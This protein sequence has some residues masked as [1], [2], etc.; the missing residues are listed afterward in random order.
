MSRRSSVSMST[1]NG[2]GVTSNRR[3]T[4]R[5]RQRRRAAIRARSFSFFSSV[6]PDCFDHA[7]NQTWRRG[8]RLICLVF[9]LLCDCAPTVFLYS[10]TSSLSPSSSSPSQRHFITGH[11][12][13]QERRTVTFYRYY[14]F[15]FSGDKVQPESMTKTSLN[16][17]TR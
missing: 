14:L 16:F 8:R 6:C 13:N 1:S 3:Q 2:S 10:V 15:I 17:A 11:P 9:R 5:G 7:A 4:V 12:L